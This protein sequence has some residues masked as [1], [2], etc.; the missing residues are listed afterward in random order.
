M[1]N[2]IEYDPTSRNDR[3]YQ[4]AT[5]VLV[6]ITIVPMRCG[7]TGPMADSGL[8]FFSGFFFHQGSTIPCFQLT[9]KKA[10]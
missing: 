7:Y 10:R 4:W 2:Y 8:L 9:Q 6:A 1:M 3:L 5:G